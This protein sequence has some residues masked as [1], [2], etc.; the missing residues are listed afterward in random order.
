MRNQELRRKDGTYIQR[1]QKRADETTWQYLKRR[2]R[3]SQEDVLNLK[4]K[5][6]G[7]K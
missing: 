2:W 7:E 6:L 1:V 4:D 5:I 3:E